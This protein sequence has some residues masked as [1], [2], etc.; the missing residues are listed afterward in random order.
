VNFLTILEKKKTRFFFFHHDTS[1][2]QLHIIHS[3]DCCIAK[4]GS[5]QDLLK[6][7]SDMHENYKGHVD[8]FMLD[9]PW[10][11][12]P[13]AVHDRLI[14]SVEV[15][16]LVGLMKTMLRVD[17]DRG[18]IAVRLESTPVQ[19]S[20][21]WKAFKEHGF[22]VN[23]LR[24]QD[25]PAASNTRAS[26]NCKKPFDTPNG[27]QWLIARRKYRD[28]HATANFGELTSPLVDLCFFFFHCSSD[29][30]SQI[31]RCPHF[32][33]PAPTSTTSRV[34]QGSGSS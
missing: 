18:V 30:V 32:P 21:W 10:G 3:S 4:P 15:P 14:P 34:C 6:A 27:H 7:G 17:D 2:T 24:I 11:V 23:V 33:P 28:Y 8:A 16:N 13:K 9:P 12:I 5:I 31:R 19:A 22:Y 29:M 25:T 20:V 26:A 1:I